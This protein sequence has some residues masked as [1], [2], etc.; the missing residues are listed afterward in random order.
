MF[1]SLG[2]CVT[3]LNT[4]AQ[5]DRCVA[6]FRPHLH[7]G[8]KQMFYYRKHGRYAGIGSK[9]TGPDGAPSL[10]GHP[11]VESEWQMAAQEQ[12]Y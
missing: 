4:P 9:I 5:G 1:R 8:G 12:L 7:K 3:G 10:P 6:V 11:R 2:Q